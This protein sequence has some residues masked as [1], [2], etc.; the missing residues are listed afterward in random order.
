M[1]KRSFIYDSASMMLGLIVASAVFFWFS[2]SYDEMLIGVVAAYLSVATLEQFLH[3]KLVKGELKSNWHRY[4]SPVGIFILL[5]IATTLNGPVQKLLGLQLLGVVIAR[6]ISMVTNDIYSYRAIHFQSVNF[7]LALGLTTFI[8]NF[9]TLAENPEIFITLLQ[10]GSFLIWLQTGF[11][12]LEFLRIRNSTEQEAENATKEN[13]FY[14]RLFSLISH[15]IRNSLST[16]LTRVELIRLVMGNAKTL[17]TYKHHIDPIESGTLEAFRLID[18]VFSRNSQTT[19][20]KIDTPVSEWL[21]AVLEDYTS[22]L[23]M[24]CIRI[25]TDWTLTQRERIAFDLAMD[26]FVSNSIKYGANHVQVTLHHSE[27]IITDDGPGVAPE[28]LKKLGQSKVA[29]DSKTGTGSGLMLSNQL[30]GLVDWKLEISSPQGEGLT[31]KMMR[32]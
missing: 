27:I 20:S 5:V 29:S 3:S 1:K 18:A 28:R 7:L 23:S 32:G 16:V 11:T 31:I 9:W 22:T 21:D 12:I 13:E 25:K 6:L 10:I 26:V 4:L 8:P 24:E 30:L 19:T 2:A 14:S 15:N 17:D